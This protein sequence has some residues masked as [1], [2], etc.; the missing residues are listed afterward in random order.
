MKSL[1]IMAFEW[2][3]FLYEHYSIEDK[4]KV[5]MDFSQYFKLEG[6][7]DEPK[8]YVRTTNEGLE[9][10][11]VATQW[12]GY[13]PSAVPGVYKKHSLSWKSLKSI[14][15]Q[16]QQELIAE[17]LMKTINSRKRQY[18]KCQFCGEIVA[19]EHRINKNTCH[20]C[21]SNLLGVVF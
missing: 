18:R 16:K 4:E 17:L 11:F 1:K 6:F 10:G 19:I 13:F 14:S 9:F 12:D 7:A 8:V 5:L 20:S 21:A 3:C 15:K 2:I